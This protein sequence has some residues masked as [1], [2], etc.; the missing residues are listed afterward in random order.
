MSKRSLIRIIILLV[1]IDFVAGCWYLASRYESTGEAFPEFWNDDDTTDVE[2]ATLVDAAVPDSFE[3]VENHK[4]FISTNPAVPGNENTRFTSIKNVYLKLPTSVNGCDSIGELIGQLMSMAFNGNTDRQSAVQAFLAKPTFNTA[5]N[6][7]YFVSDKSPTTLKSYGNVRTNK[8]YP[9]LTSQAMLVFQNDVSVFDGTSTT[10]ASHFLHYDRVNQ[11]VYNYYD[12]IEKESEEKLLE[13][14]N[15]KIDWL[16][17]NKNM[18]MSHATALPL[19]FCVKQKGI[20]FEFPA[21]VIAAATSGPID[22]FIEKNEVKPLLVS[23][24]AK[25]YA[26][27]TG[28]WTYQ[29]PK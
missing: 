14:L 25:Q 22:V 24:F 15:A 21:G 19:E 17:Q 1:V 9:L 23:N 2:A 7:A 8:V 16:N 13:K 29:Q 3:V 18:T 12:I 4:Y 20:M 27:N 28:W 5:E 10:K 26:A 6:V 11:R